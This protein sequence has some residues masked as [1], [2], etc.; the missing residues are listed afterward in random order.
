MV[1]I[2]DP[3][4]LEIEQEDLCELETSLRTNKQAKNNNTKRSEA[5]E[6][7]QG[8]GLVSQG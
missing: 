8:K 7:S 4:I 3:S 5:R 1:H 2:F 6:I